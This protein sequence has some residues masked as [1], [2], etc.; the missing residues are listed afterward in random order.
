MTKPF[1]A[2]VN[3]SRNKFSCHN[4]E[5][6]W[7]FLKEFTLVIFLSS[8][9]REFHSFGPDTEKAWSPT[10]VHVLGTTKRSRLVDLSDPVSLWSSSCSWFA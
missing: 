3:K 8:L 5:K 9:G 4:I 10:R 7:V 1:M 6:R 2:Q